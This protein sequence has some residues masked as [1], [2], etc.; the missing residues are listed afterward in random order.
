LFSNYSTDIIKDVDNDFNSLI[1]ELS[2]FEFPT[3]SSST[4]KEETVLDEQE[5]SQYFLNKSKAIIEAGVNAVQDMAPYVAQTQDPKEISALAELMTATTQALDSLNKGA[6]INKKA[7]RDEKLE[8][9]KIEGRKELMD[10][11]DK[12]QNITNNVNVVV[13]SREEIVKKLFGKTVQELPLN[14]K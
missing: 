6:L 10:F 11:S 5:A 2:S 14:D 8:K 7:D 13:A 1:D 12:K 9:I 3:Q 4:K